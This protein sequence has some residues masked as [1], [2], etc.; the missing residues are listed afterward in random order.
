MGNGKFEKRICEKCRAELRARKK[1]YLK[2]KWLGFL[3]RAKE[4]CAF[5]KNFFIENAI[6]FF[7]K[8]AFFFK[9]LRP[10][11][12]FKLVFGSVASFL[13]KFGLFL[14]N[15]FKPFKKSKKR[16]CEKCRAELRA[17]KKQREQEKREKRKAKWLDLLGRAKRAYEI[18]FLKR[19]FD[20]KV[21]P[22]LKKTAF[23]VRE[24]KLFKKLSPFFEKV[25]VF[26]KRLKPLFKIAARA[27]KSLAIFFKGLFESFK[28]FKRGRYFIK[29]CVAV[30][31]ILPFF[32]I[33]ICEFVTF[34]S[35]AAVFAMFTNRFMM[36]L[37]IY[38][39]FLMFSAALSLLFKNTAISFSLISLV[40]IFLSIL[41]SVRYAITSEPLVP[42]DIF[43]LKDIGKVMGFSSGAFKLNGAMVFASTAFVVFSAAAVVFNITPKAKRGRIFGLGFCFLSGFIFVFVSG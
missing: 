19:F 4:A 29:A 32:V 38:T 22:A 2:A 27:L 5:F 3:V 23:F 41:N 42:A 11:K 31:L 16:T 30:N 12:L 9:G 21:I 26:F 14:K 18:S 25:A 24:H 40:F 17:H 33:W 36:V 34:K 15:L 20:E 43:M 10:L 35:A 37:L 39:I 6:P 7:K 1:Q 8:A 28:E 13:K